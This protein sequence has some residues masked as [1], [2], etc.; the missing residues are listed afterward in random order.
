MRLATSAMIH[1]SG[2]ASPGAGRKR[3]LARDAA[4]GIGDRAVLLAPARAA[5][6]HDVGEAGGVGLGH[7]VGDDD[8]GTGLDRRLARRRRRACDRPGW[9]P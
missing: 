4:L 5:G 9:S 7:D 3:A 2:R 1:Q 6:K 8:E